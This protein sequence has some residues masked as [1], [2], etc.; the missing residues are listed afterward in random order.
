MTLVVCWL[1]FPIVIGAVSLGCGLLL[2]KATGERVGGA[3]LLPVGLAVLVLLPQLAIGAGINDA[4][5][6]L[7]LVAAVAGFALGWPTLR[8]RVGHIDRWALGAAAL[9]YLVFAAPILL[10]GQAS[11]AGFIM[12][13]DTST[14]SALVDHFYA[15]G[16]DFKGLPQSTFEATVQINLS[17]GYPV[18]S[19]L[20]IET[21]RPLVGQDLL[22]IYQPYLAYLAAMVS[23]C[24]YALVSG[25]VETPRRRFVI[26]AIAAQP[27]ILFAYAMQGGVKEL[28]ASWLLALTAAVAVPL[29]RGAGSIRSVIP[30]AVVLGAFLSTLGAGGGAWAAPILLGVAIA[31][32]TKRRTRIDRILQAKQAGLFVV[33]AGVITAA[34]LHDVNFLKGSALDVL[35]ANED[36]GNLITPLS[37]FQVFGVWPGADYRLAL[38]SGLTFAYALIAVMAGLA[39]AGVAYTVVRRRFDLLAFLLGALASFVLIS[40][41]SGLWVDAKAIATVAPVFVC[42]TLLGAAWVSRAGVPVLAIGVVVLVAAGIGYTNVQTYGHVSRA[43]RPAARGRADRQGHRLGGADARQRIQPLRRA[44][45]ASQGRAGGPVGAAPPPGAAQQRP[46]PAQGRRRRPRPLLAAGAPGVPDDRQPQEPRPE[47]AAVE[48]QADPRRLL[49][50]GVAAAG[51]RGGLGH[52]GPHRRRRLRPR[53][54][55]PGLPVDHDVRGQGSGRQGAAPARRVQAREPHGRAAALT[56]Q[57]ETWVLDADRRRI[58]DPDPG[59]AKATFTVEKA[60]RYHAWQGGSFARGVDVKIDGRS[61]GA[62][63]WQ[64]ANLGQFKPLGTITLTAGRH[65]YE[66]VRGGRSVHPGGGLR[67]GPVFLEGL[68][69]FALEPVSSAWNV[70]TVA[71]SQA[72]SRICGKTVDWI[73]LVRPG[74]SIP[75]PAPAQAAP[76][77]Q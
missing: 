76:A 56:G 65:T 50:H 73:E 15:H 62:A 47:P 16:R 34:I 41:K 19:M 64:M 3:L 52:P 25:L 77:A 53:G 67:P 33:L 71:P 66:V 4:A 70:V 10:S 23:L 61:I 14:F 59:S 12:L 22:W 55:R 28:A 35:S 60:G 18:G 26:A 45:P 44:P 75:G 7:V 32:V 24:L 51:G 54:E 49:L 13:D 43:A 5:R 31:A 8:E 40:T 72:R 1:A 20:P 39:I 17:Q 63:R 48:L 29:A 36:R 2:E 68:G 74:A 27:G 46:V 6:P 57:P 11:F 58:S 37:K 69:P 42:A 9:V 38:G 21:V 30:A